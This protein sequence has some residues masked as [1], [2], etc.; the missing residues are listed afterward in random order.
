MPVP[1]GIIILVTH[2]QGTTPLVMRAG[3]A[4]SLLA[5]LNDQAATI[6]NT[7]TMLG[8]DNLD[9]SNVDM[10]Q[11]ILSSLIQQGFQ[12]VLMPTMTESDGVDELKSQRAM[13]SNMIKEMHHFGVQLTLP[14]MDP[15]HVEIF[16]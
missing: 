9:P 7:P 4:L 8:D 13:I 12:K 1:K 2:E 5:L 3:F 14:T 16:H 6:P 10:I 11:P 15:R